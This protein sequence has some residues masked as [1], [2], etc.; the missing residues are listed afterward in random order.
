M[1]FMRSNEDLVRLWCLGY[2]M[3]LDSSI[4]E[5][6]DQAMFQSPQWNFT[7][8]TRLSFSYYMNLS[9]T[10]KGTALK[11]YKVSQLQA[12]EQLLFSTSSGKGVWKSIYICL[13]V[14]VYSLAFVGTVDRNY[15]SDIGLDDV[16]IDNAST[17]CI[18]QSVSTTLS[19]LDLIV[20][21]R[22]Y[23]KIQWRFNS[24]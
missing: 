18:V 22:R 24:I 3:L 23:F 11:I 12:Y 5:P 19:K 6:G 20:S 15:L 17:S 8:P 4:G 2:Y 9:S 14:G 21:Q 13:P 16:V 10:D 1:R 7:M